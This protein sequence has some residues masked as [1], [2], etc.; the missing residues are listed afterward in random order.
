[1]NN[2]VTAN[3]K[4]SNTTNTQREELSL[5]E[6]EKYVSTTKILKANT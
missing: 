1:M 2:I 5:K 6:N 3:E 4:N